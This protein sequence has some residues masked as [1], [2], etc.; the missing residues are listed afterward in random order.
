VR[1]GR[2]GALIDRSGA[3]LSTA[4]GRPCCSREMLGARRSS[5]SGGR[6]GSEPEPQ[7]R[8][9]A[10]TLTRKRKTKAGSGDRDFVGEKNCQIEQQNVQSPSPS[11]NLALRQSSLILAP[12]IARQAAVL[13]RLGLLS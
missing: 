5:K 6:S 1:R 11:R 2:L 13:Y 10:K 7:T 9:E 8:R 12:A 3:T 4:M